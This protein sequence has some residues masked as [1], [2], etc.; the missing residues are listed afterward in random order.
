[1]SV[2]HTQRKPTA[3]VRMMVFPVACGLFLF[4]LFF[5][6]WYFQVVLSAALTERAS[7]AAHA[8]L[9]VLAPRGLI[10]DRDGRLIAGVKPA[11]VVTAIPKVVHD[12]PE[13]LSRL[14]EML[15]TTVAKLKRKLKKG[16]NRNL[17]VPIF[18]G[19]TLEVGTRIAE[20]E[21]DLPGIDVK[22]EP[23]R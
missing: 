12:H 18:V 9:D 19:A 4:A 11:L 20:G 3:D 15:G 2:I 17:P 23:M 21:E 16:L 10:F 7:L 6:L 8:K 14:A 1:M 5:R 22:T 13:V